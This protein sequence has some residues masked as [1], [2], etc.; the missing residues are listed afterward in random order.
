[1]TDAKCYTIGLWKN[2]SIVLEKLFH[3]LHNMYIPIRYNV[4]NTYIIYDDILMLIT[5][6]VKKSR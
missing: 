2:S 4:Y 6:L 3:G 5:E 1:M